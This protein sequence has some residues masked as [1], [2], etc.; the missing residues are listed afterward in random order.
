MD[1]TAP[2][3]AAPSAGGPAHLR[4]HG[5]ASTWPLADVVDALERAVVAGRGAPPSGAA[6]GWAGAVRR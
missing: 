4:V 5:L 3:P 2:T 1:E 6:A